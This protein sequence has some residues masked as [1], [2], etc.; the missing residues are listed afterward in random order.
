MFY[1]DITAIVTTKTLNISEE[2]IDLSVKLLYLGLGVDSINMVSGVTG[3][4][5]SQEIRFCIDP[6]R[7]R[8]L[9]HLIL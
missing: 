6:L 9:T 1:K 7:T 3:A 5:V 4:I 2:I 8:C